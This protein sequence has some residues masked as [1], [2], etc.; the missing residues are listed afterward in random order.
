M[1]KDP[2]KGWCKTADGK[3]LNS[4]HMENQKSKHI[5]GDSRSKSSYGRSYVKMNTILVH[6][7]TIYWEKNYEET[8]DCKYILL[9]VW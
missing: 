8:A 1:G 4:H 7:S 9:C 2:L 6:S 3:T 5:F